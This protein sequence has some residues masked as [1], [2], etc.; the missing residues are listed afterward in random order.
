LGHA[1]IHFKAREDAAAALEKFQGHDLEGRK[2]SIEWCI[3]Q[4]AKANRK[5]AFEERGPAARPFVGGPGDRYAAGG[6]DRFGGGDRFGGDRFGARPPPVDER[7]ARRPRYDEPQG[8]FGGFRGGYEEP[9]RPAPRDYYEEPAP[10]PYSAPPV[11]SAAPFQEYNSNVSHA[12]DTLLSLASSL[13]RSGT[14]FN[15]PPAQQQYSGGNNSYG[16]GAAPQY[17]GG[18]PEYGYNRPVDRGY[19][20]Y[21]R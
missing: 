6:Y 19:N 20:P 7:P 9:R 21:S 11:Q 5:R 15:A 13:T 14:G 1:F 17:G 3:P 8:G 4:E 12:R 2:L 10:I 18:A 16:G